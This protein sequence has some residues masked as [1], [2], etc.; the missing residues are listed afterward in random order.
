MLPWLASAEPAA[1]LH[2]LKDVPLARLVHKEILRAILRGEL[3]PGDKISDSILAEKLRVSRMPVREALRDLEGSGLVESRKHTGVFVRMPTPR[4]IAELYELRAALDALAGRK[5]AAS[6]SPA[7]IAQLEQRL[8]V[9]QAATERNDV[10]AYYQSN[11]EFHW[12]IVSAAG[13]QE[14]ATMYRGIAQRV[15]MARLKS[16]SSDVAMMSSVRDHHRIVDT[17]RAADPDACAALMSAHV[18]RAV[19]R[20]QAQQ[21]IPSP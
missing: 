4:E 2:D 6:A 16:L 21:A 15:H 9:M 20:L 1:S 13:S 5:V 17:I 19:V 18:Q 8:A 12:D 7:L 10:L 14:L 3:L 11:L